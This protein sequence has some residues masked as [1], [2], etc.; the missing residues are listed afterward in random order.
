MISH[1]AKINIQCTILELTVVHMELSGKL[2][3]LFESLHLS[4]IIA[5]SWP[6]T[7]R[8]SGGNSHRQTTAYPAVRGPHRS[9]CYATFRAGESVVVLIRWF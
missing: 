8:T 9:H 2:L 4:F 6:N 1:A 5:V 3:T 7:E